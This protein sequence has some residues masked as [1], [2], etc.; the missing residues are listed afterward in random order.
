M[1]ALTVGKTRRFRAACVGAP[2]ANLTSQ[3][4]TWDGGAYFVDAMALDPWTGRSG[5]GPT[6]R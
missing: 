1:S 3:F 6:L 2:I 4:G 5:T